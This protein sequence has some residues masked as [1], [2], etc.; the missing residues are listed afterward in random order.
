MVAPPGL[1]CSLSVLRATS[2]GATRPVAG[3]EEERI[4]M[5]KACFGRV[6]R[7]GIDS[8]RARRRAQQRRAKPQAEALEAICLLTAV[9]PGVA[10]AAARLAPHALV[11]S[12]DRAALLRLSQEP[13][14]GTASAAVQARRAVASGRPMQDRVAA[15]LAA[16]RQHL[17]RPQE[18]PV[19]PIRLGQ[20]RTPQVARPV[21]SVRPVADASIRPVLGIKA[22]RPTPRAVLKAPVG[23]ASAPVLA[24]VPATLIVAATEQRINVRAFGAVGDGIVD[25]KAAIE[26]AFRAA[27]DTGVETVYFPAGTY[28]VALSNVTPNTTNRITV[29]DGIRIVGA[30][31]AVSTIRFD[32]GAN[33]TFAWQGL[34]INPQFSVDVSD[35]SLR[36]PDTP[37][38]QADGSTG[39][40]NS[41]LVF[42]DGARAGAVYDAT[43]SLTDCDVIGEVGSA[44]LCNS[45]TQ[46]AWSGRLILEL[47]NC[48]VTGGLQNLAVFSG[49][50][51]DD[52]LVAVHAYNSRFEGAGIPAALSWQHVDSG[53]A[54]YIHPNVS[55]IAEDCVFGADERL[56]S[57]VYAIQHYGSAP[58]GSPQYV[59][60]T[61]CTFDSTAVNA[62][63]NTERMGVTT[64]VEDCTFNNQARA[65]NVRGSIT[66][67]RCTFNQGGSVVYGSVQSINAEEQAA[68]VTTL[69]DCAIN[70]GYLL[71]PFPTSTLR[72]VRCEIKTS[73]SNPTYIQNLGTATLEMID[74]YDTSTVTTLIDANQ[75]IT[76][77]KGCTFRGKYAKGAVRFGVLTTRLT[78]VNNNFYGEEILTPGT[79]CAL[80]SYTLAIHGR[81]SLDVIWGRGNA[82]RVA[83]FTDMY[84]SVNGLLGGI[85]ASLWGP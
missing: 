39:N 35:L 49:Y 70:S 11:G 1:T 20:I 9:P 27:I 45:G 62:L 21:G 3:P 85:P 82:Y 64:L 13:A 15:R 32:P 2:S 80:Y 72:L 81:P 48:N 79:S 50:T 31:R 76:T 7:H 22:V 57:R 37:T 41:Y 34:W 83:G 24:T 66:A 18:T 30:G 61:R 33:D 77:I 19:T 10:L 69:E 25:D 16:L 38:V 78:L 84:L 53:H 40:L 17:S 60:L 71:Q 6:G 65:L 68:S 42:R 36:G 55:I 67:R 44:V 5:L 46:L 63:L 59:R 14:S 23:T 43:I 8:N 58:I 52:A 12:V 26:A 51:S 54:W 56:T 73:L 4:L 74:C 29:P 75:G 28:R 47:R